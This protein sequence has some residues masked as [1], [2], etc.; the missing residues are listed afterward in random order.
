MDS[1]SEGLSSLL[2]TRLFTI[3]G[4]DTTVGSALAVVAILVATY[5]VA[6]S[7]RRVAARIFKRH[8]VD[9]DIAVQTTATV[10]QVVAWLAGIEIVLHLLGIR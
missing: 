3:S 2:D 8:G 1:Q 7:M 9:D 10:L 4:T 5:L 6:R